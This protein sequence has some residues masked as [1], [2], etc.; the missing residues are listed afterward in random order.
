MQE[1]MLKLF[2]ELGAS[3]ASA[4]DAYSFFFFSPYPVPFE[5]KERNH[6]CHCNTH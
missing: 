6:K 1:S 5:K 2:E 4:S 3:P